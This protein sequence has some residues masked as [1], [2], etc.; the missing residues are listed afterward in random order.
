MYW[1]ASSIMRDSINRLSRIVLLQITGNNYE[2]KFNNVEW[3]SSELPS[4]LATQTTARDN[5]TYEARISTGIVE[6][7][8][9]LITW[10]V[11]WSTLALDIIVSRSF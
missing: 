9:Q 5:K 7:V 11:L 2:V 3:R 6:H 1:L 4:T 10:L 8:H